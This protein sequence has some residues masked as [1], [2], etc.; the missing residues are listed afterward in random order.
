M[1]NPRTSTHSITRRGGRP[2]SPRAAPV[3]MAR[4]IKAVAAI[5]GKCSCSA[6][7][8]TCSSVK[9]DN[10]TQ[11]SKLIIKS[12]RKL[13]AKPTRS[14]MPCLGRPYFPSACFF[15][16]FQV[17][18]KSEGAV[19]LAAGSSAEPPPSTV[20]RGIGDELRLAVVRHFQLM[21]LAEQAR[22]LDRIVRR[23]NSRFHL[24]VRLRSGDR[25]GTPFLPFFYFNTRADKLLDLIRHE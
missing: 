1:R 18:A 17:R 7:A 2:R 23:R 16:S 24:C 10:A 6:I 3:P 4:L 5:S 25:W 13:R 9:P 14:L 12:H 8:R 21:A 20:G 11:S 15:Q 19:S 22:V